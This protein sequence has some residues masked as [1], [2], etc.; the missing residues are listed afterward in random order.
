MAQIPDAVVSLG[1]FNDNAF[2]QV[3]KYITG[4]PKLAN[5]AEEHRYKAVAINK[6]NGDLK[7][8]GDGD[9]VVGILYET[10]KIG[11]PCQIAASGFAYVKVGAGGIKPGDAVK[12]VAG[13]AVA[14]GADDVSNI[15]CVKA[16]AAGNIGTVLLAR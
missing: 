9:L 8:A 11:E 16:G 15:V 14:A 13:A 5:I 6:T 1:I 7:L 12:F 10:G 4:T 2:T 3:W